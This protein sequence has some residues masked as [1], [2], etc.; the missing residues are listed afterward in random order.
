[1]I[2]V[3][4][5]LV[6]CNSMNNES[7]AETYEQPA[8]ETISAEETAVPEQTEEED[9]K[10]TSAQIVLDSNLAV[11]KARETLFK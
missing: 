8:A 1:M 9:M 5:L 6:S 10:E 2:A 7:P 4:S 3:M 11:K